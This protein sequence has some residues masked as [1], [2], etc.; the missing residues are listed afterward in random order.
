[1]I[2]SISSAFATARKLKWITNPVRMQ[3][4][5]IH[6]MTT[7]RPSPPILLFRRLIDDVTERFVLDA[8]SPVEQPS[9]LV[10]P[11]DEWLSKG[12]AKSYVYQV[13]HADNQTF[14]LRLRRPRFAETLRNQGSQLSRIIAATWPSTLSHKLQT[15]L[16]GFSLTA[17]DISREAL[18]Q[19]NR[20]ASAS[21][22]T[23]PTY[24]CDMRGI[25]E[26][27]PNGSFD[28]VMS[29]D[30]SVPH[31]Q[32]DAEI[33]QAIQS[34]VSCARPGGNGRRYVLYQ[35]WDFEG[36]RN[37]IALYCLVSRSTYYAIGIGE[38]CIDAGS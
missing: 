19:L 20:A 16:P 9:P 25:H 14:K 7:A 29:A 36:D 1:M 8:S 30:N 17:S 31:L 15:S 27:F 13:T 37:K 5:L 22:L 10:P 11:Q 28:V 3:N 33:L 6:Q 24:L 23:I 38:C 18:D 32:T 4:K 2:S 35:L 21:Q 26:H 12:G 34:M